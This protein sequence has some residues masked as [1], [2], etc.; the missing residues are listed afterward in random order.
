M[1]SGLR[2]VRIR[3]FE[4]QQE[5]FGEEHAHPRRIEPGGS[6]RTADE[7]DGAAHAEFLI[8]AAQL[9]SEACQGIEHMRQAHEEVIAPHGIPVEGKG[10]LVV[11]ALVLLDEK[12]RFDASPDA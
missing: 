5:R 4:L 8:Q 3:L 11:V 10:M 1:G 6:A 9:P 7:G 2:P 12:A